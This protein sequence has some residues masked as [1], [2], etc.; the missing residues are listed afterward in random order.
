MRERRRTRMPG[1]IVKRQYALRLRCSGCGR[2]L[3]GDV[4]RYRHPAPTCE[5]FIA[6]T[7]TV[8]RRYRIR[9]RQ[10]GPGPLL[11]AGVVRGRHRRTA[12]P[13]W[14]PRRPHDQRG[15]PPVP[16]SPGTDR[17]RLTGQDRPRARGGRT[18][19]G[20]T[21]DVLAWQREMA[22]ARRGGAGSARSGRA[23]PTLVGRGCR[24]PALAAR[25]SGRTP[26]PKV[27]KRWRLRS[28][29]AQTSWGSSGWST[30]SRPM[31]S[32][33]ASVRR[34][35]PSSRS[36]PARSVSLVGARGVW[37]NTFQHPRH[38]DPEPSA[39]HGRPRRNFRFGSRLFSRAAGHP[40]TAP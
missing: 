13:G 34:F 38:R 8:R 7:P 6:A 21:R 15:R 12:R 16:R 37:A 27:A 9:D 28:S 20:R 33:S 36:S 25:R 24:L 18:A 30:N 35:R 10:A 2:F 22:A 17:S 31:R 26:G 19:P 29:R 5:A 1:R 14:H 40:G 11:P 3:Y 32:N 39:R 23:G 4:G